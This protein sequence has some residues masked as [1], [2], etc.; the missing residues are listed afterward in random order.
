LH[1]NTPINIRVTITAVASLRT[2]IRKDGTTYI[3]VSR[4][5]RE[6]GISATDIA[7]LLGASCAT[8]YRYLSAPTTA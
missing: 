4:S 3:Q 2:G 7:K 1:I 6:R 8:V 5:L